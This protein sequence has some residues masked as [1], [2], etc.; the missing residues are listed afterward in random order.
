[1]SI[2]LYTAYKVRRPDLL[3]KTLRSIQKTAQE[4]VKRILRNVYQDE[5]HVVD[6][7]SAVFQDLVHQYGGDDWAA[8]FS[9][10]SKLIRE[11]YREAA[12]GVARSLYD[13]D[14]YLTLREFEGGVYIIPYCD[15]KMRDVLKFLDS[16]KRL[17]DFHFQTQTERPQGVSSR[18][19]ANRRRVWEGIDKAGWR[20]FLRLDICNFELLWDLAPQRSKEIGR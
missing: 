20:A 11:R 3:W 14:V 9:I 4:E 10:A 15:M 12:T 19:W 5:M 1:M 8:K 7:T 17:S 13:F 18:V 2:K 6:K 16:D